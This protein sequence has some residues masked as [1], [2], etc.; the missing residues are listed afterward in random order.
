MTKEDEHCMHVYGEKDDDHF[1]CLNTKIDPET[2]V[3]KL[4]EIKKK[5]YN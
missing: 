2:K 3:N 5:K 4:E 1:W